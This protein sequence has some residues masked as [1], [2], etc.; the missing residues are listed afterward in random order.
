MPVLILCVDPDMAFLSS[1]EKSLGESFS[2]VKAQSGAKAMELAGQVQ[3][4]ALAVVS[5][6]LP[7]MDGVELL[8]TLASKLP[9]VGRIAVM[10]D[11]DCD[12]LTRA[13]NATGVDGV[14]HKPVRPK[15]LLAV[16]KRGHR[17]RQDCRQDVQLKDAL[18]GSVK[19]LLDLMEIIDPL[20]LGRSKRAFKRAMEL[21][22]RLKAKSP[23]QLEMAVMLSHIGCLVL[24]IELTRKL[25]AGQDFSPEEQKLFFRH[26]AIAAKLLSNIKRMEDVATIV[27]HQ[28]SKYSDKLPLESR[29][30][31]AVLDLDRQ[32]RK[33]LEP[34]DAMAVLKKRA[35]QYDPRVLEALED[36]SDTGGGEVEEVEAADL[37]PGMIMARDLKNAEGVVLLLKG[38]HLTHASTTRL[39]LFA[40]DLGLKGPVQVVAGKRAKLEPV[41]ASAEGGDGVEP[42]AEAASVPGDA[43]AGQETSG[44]G[45]SG[46]GA[47]ARGAS[48][49]ETKT[50][51]R[52]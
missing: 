26:P 2:L 1:L 50:P 4:I 43:A 30:L 28:N 37:E 42:V 32:E 10:T 21:G 20:A 40:V 16:L 49:Q 23:W 33:G 22:R 12:A 5:L 14:L 11:R 44:Q 35:D 3:G 24:P 39:K 45:A 13:V 8:T 51:P 18:R 19:V 27:L 48:G 6:T 46:Q 29:I 52:D 17:R 9:D 34:S 31:K 25:D 47:S 15:E 38:Q 41:A 36:M 7:D